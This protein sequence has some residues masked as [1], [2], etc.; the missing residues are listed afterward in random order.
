MTDAFT[1]RPI[2]RV[3]CARAEPIDDNW[4]AFPAAIELDAARF[5]A[6]ALQGLDAFSHVEVLYIFDQVD[7]ETINTTARRPRGR[8]DWPK[9]GIFAQRGKG[10]PNR[11]G[12]TICAV[13]SVR[14]TILHVAGLD[15]IDGT[16]V[17]DLKPVLSG[18]QPRGPF[19]EPDW[20]VEI[21]SG[22]WTSKD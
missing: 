16:P 18:F 4:D 9:V 21:M 20:A 12:A 15:A 17:I 5:G 8:A 14:G 19:R 3:R 1:I 6:E 7:D 10:R 13:V 22:Y 2:G 11:I